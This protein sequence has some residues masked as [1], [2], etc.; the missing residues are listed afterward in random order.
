MLALVAA[1]GC[2]DHDGFVH[3][4]LVVE[5]LSTEA[6]YVDVSY[7][8]HGTDRFTLSGGTGIVLEYPTE[9]LSVSITRVFDGAV[10]FQTTLTEEDF[11]A[12]NGQIDISIRP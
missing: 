12:S 7:A 8:G 10:L 4:T 11:D 6:A 1:A 3:H 9:T 5:N 2:H